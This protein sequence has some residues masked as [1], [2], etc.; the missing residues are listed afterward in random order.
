[1]TARRFAALAL[2]LALGAGTA[3]AQTVRPVL[4]DSLRVKVAAGE[5]IRVPLSIDMTSAGVV[6]LAHLI[7]GVT[8]GVNRLTFD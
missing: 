1:M 3:R 2:A 7:T 5:K 6:T 4:G 8:W